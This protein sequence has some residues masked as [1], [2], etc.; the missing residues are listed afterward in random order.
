MVEPVE[1]DVPALVASQK[2][3]ADTGTSVND[4]ASDRRQGDSFLAGVPN[5]LLA[6]GR[7]VVAQWP[8][9]K[10]CLELI[11]K[12]HETSPRLKFGRTTDPNR[13]YRD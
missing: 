4:I 10:R 3:T 11:D 13:F 5:S 7:A 1:P 12:R 6:A 9:L 2:P 8:R